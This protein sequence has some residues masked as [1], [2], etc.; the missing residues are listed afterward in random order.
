[1]PTPVATLVENADRQGRQLALPTE[2]ETVRNDVVGLG[3]CQHLGLPSVLR[4]RKRKQARN[5][6]EPARLH[7]FGLGLRRR[8]RHRLAEAA[9]KFS[10]RN[11]GS[12]HLCT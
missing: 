4:S 10:A 11:E 9:D 2:T 3:E 6:F 1:M 12:Q 8:H 7:P 5:V